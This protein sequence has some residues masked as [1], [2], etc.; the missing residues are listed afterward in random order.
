MAGVRTLPTTSAPAKV[1]GLLFVAVLALTACSSDPEEQAD[2]TV[3]QVAEDLV[4]NQVAETAG[5]G[6]LSPA[7]PDVVDPLVGTAW[8][9]TATTGDQR[10]VAVDAVI[11]NTGRVKLTTTNVITAGALP[12]FERAAVAA[13]NNTVGSRLTDDAIDCGDQSILLGTDPAAERVMVCALLDP[14][15]ELTYDVNLSITD[16]ETRQFSLV[17]ADQPRS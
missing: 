14:H 4:R 10:V 7:C 1:A 15:N 6:D 12:S 13:L 5:L 2:P 17:V 11:D 3:R 9:C 8:Q 16:I